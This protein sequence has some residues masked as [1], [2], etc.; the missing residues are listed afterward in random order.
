MFAIAPYSVVLNDDRQQPIDLWALPGKHSL[1]SVLLSYYSQELNTYTPIGSNKLFRIAKMFQGDSNSIA[2]SYETGEHGTESPLYDVRR[3]QISHKKKKTEADMVPFNFLWVFPKSDIAARRK[4]GLLL[5]ARHKNL[6]IR[7][8]TIP[9]LKHYVEGSF[10]GLSLEVQRMVPAT[11]AHS[12][13]SKGTLKAIRLIRR[14]FPSTLEGLLT[15]DDKA[16]FQ[17]IEI[18]VKAKKKGGFGSERFANLLAGEGNMQSFYVSDDLQCDNIKLDVEVGG[19]M[20]RIDVGRQ[21]VMSNVEITDEIDLDATGFP[22]IESW[23]AYADDMAGSLLSSRAF[24]M[25]VK[26]AIE[27][28]DAGTT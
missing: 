4:R 13:A 19:R 6:G 11:L 12:I 14:R 2:G 16:S 25:R 27:E 1:R 10:P 17:S 28:L 24:Q 22:T 21:R 20:R 18:V 23:Y 15:E 3:K 26:T 9:H 7:T 5:L 8:I